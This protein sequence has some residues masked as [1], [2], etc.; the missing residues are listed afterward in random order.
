MALKSTKGAI[1]EKKFITH[2]MGVQIPYCLGSEAKA[3]G[4]IW[5]VARG[6][7]HD[8]EKVV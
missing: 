6:A 7:S 4:H 5:E 8:T 2:G 3:Q 1:S